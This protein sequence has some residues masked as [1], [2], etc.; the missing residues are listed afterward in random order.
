MNIIFN[1][2][3]YHCFYLQPH[4]AVIR[5]DVCCSN[6]GSQFYLILGWAFFFL[7]CPVCAGKLWW[8]KSGKKRYPR[9]SVRSGFHVWCLHRVFIQ[10]GFSSLT[11]PKLTLPELSLSHSTSGP[12]CRCCLVPAGIRLDQWALQQLSPFPCSQI[13][14]RTCVSWSLLQQTIPRSSCCFLPVLAVLGCDREHSYI[15]TC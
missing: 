12:G 14:S 1:S 2:A 11:L 8:G 9:S 6:L 15:C 7:A 5:D 4:W 3:F 13:F 10:V